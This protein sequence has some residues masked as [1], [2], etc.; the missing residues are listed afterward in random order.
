[1]SLICAFV[2]PQAVTVAVDTAVIASDGSMSSTSKMVPLVHYPAVIA[3]RG[4]ALFLEMI[5]S[6]CHA[7][8]GT[9]DDLLEAMPKLLVEV[10]PQFRRLAQQL[11]TTDERLLG[12]HNVILAGWSERQGRMI[13]RAYAQDS[14]DE[15]FGVDDIQNMYGA[16]WDS[17][18]IALAPDVMRFASAQVRLMHAKAP[19]ATVGGRL[20]VARITKDGL[21]VQHAGDL[22][23]RPIRRPAVLLGG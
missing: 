10:T 16:P 12:T 20:I 1:M 9:F 7:I 14:A 17:S 22:P 5:F 18:L 13:C 8:G 23:G 2:T 19:E 6:G 3:Y 21:S 15:G 11:G 4:C